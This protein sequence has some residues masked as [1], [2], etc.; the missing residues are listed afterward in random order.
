MPSNAVMDRKMF[1]VERNIPV[2]VSIDDLVATFS[3][4]V[5]FS[6]TVKLAILVHRRVLVMVS[7]FMLK[8]LY[9]V[10]YASR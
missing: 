7:V 6:V 4:I 2:P 8:E 10:L 3:S 5:V 1:K 9:N